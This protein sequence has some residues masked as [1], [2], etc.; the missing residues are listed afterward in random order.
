MSAIE[1]ASVGAVPV[2]RLG[3]SATAAFLVAWDIV[4]ICLQTTTN[5]TVKLLLNLLLHHLLFRQLLMM[6]SHP[7]MMTS[8][9]LNPIYHYTL[10]LLN[11]KLPVIS[12]CLQ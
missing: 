11:S 6:T 9:P 10:N 4:R 3:L 7:L 12:L 8:H 1:L 5:P 2:Q